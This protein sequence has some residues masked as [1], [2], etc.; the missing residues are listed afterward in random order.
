M[1]RQSASDYIRQYHNLPVHAIGPDGRP[2]AE[3]VNVTKYQISS[4]DERS[5]LLGAIKKVL[6]LPSKPHLSG[7]YGYFTFPAGDVMGSTEPF[8]WQTIR[9]AYGFKA[10][11]AEIRD[12]IRL[13]YRLGRIGMG[14][15]VAGQPADSPT[16]ALYAA[17]HFGLDCNGFVGNYYNLSPEVKPGGWATISSF[18]ENKVLKKTA[19]D[20]GWNGWV[21]AAVLTLDHIPLIPRMSATEAR[22][23]D[24]LVD[25]RLANN[26]WAHIA[27]VQ[28]V[29]PGPGKDQVTWRVVEWGGG[30]KASEVGL[31]ANDHVKAEKT[32]NITMGTIKKLGVGCFNKTDPKQATRFR[33]LF[34]PP[35]VSYDPAMWGRCGQE[36]I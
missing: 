16:M 28:D 10:T 2:M 34:A 27:V 8:Y 24:I 29:R 12:V 9:R 36:N 31:D 25:Q 14:K 21:K 15:D 26:T 20:D 11:P 32:V 33:Y 30:I 23:G 35:N 4:P 5:K 19:E 18:D 6:G 1:G 7:N 22:T 3:T 13:A 17:K